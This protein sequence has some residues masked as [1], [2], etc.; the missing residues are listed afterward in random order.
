MDRRIPSLDGARAVSISLV[1]ASHIIAAHVGDNLPLFLKF[2]YGNLGVRVFFVISGF[3]ITSL[4]LR[5]HERTGRIS[6]KGFY[7]RRFFRIV[8]AFYALV[9]TVAILIYM[10]AVPAHYSGLLPALFYYSNY[11][12]VPL[13]LGHTWSL[14][15]EEQFYLLWP[16]SLV[17]LGLRRSLVGPALLLLAAPSFRI[18]DHVGMWHTEARYAFETVCDALATG[19]LL[20]ILRGKLWTLP[21]Y[22]CVVE[23]P[24]CILVSASA[25]LVMGAHLSWLLHDVIGMPLLNIG[26]AM[27]LDRYMRQPTSLIGRFLNIA[28]VVWIGTLSYSL[29]LWQQLFVFRSIPVLVKVAAILACAAI[30]Y[31]LIE[32]PFLRIRM[33]LT[34]RQELVPIAAPA[35]AL[36]K[37]SP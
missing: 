14:S 26:I 31:Y 16:S 9:L 23:S 28:P 27:A 2:D 32:R 5:E 30:S 15:V 20:A 33:R 4:L 6:L 12:G 17:L 8:P 11:R 21:V 10:G 36:E 7:L 34:E 25:L 19:C 29:Y 18:L 24:Y 3:L 37:P 35:S 13:A 22:R 1:I